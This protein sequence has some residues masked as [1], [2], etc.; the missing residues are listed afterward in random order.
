[1]GSIL[2]EKC[3]ICCKDFLSFYH[4]VGMTEQTIFFQVLVHSSRG[5]CRREK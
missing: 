4:L 1:M 5:H 3:D 2:G